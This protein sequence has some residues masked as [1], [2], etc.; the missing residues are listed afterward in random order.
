MS[1]AITPITPA[2]DAI[3]SQHRV[4]IDEAQKRDV[5]ARLSSDDQDKRVQD[6]TAALAIRL[7]RLRSQDQAL[8]NIKDALNVSAAA[9]AAIGDSAAILSRLKELAL[10]STSEALSVSE[11]A[12]VQIEF[13][14]L[15][16]ELD[17]LAT[18][19][20]SGRASTEEATAVE[21][22][23]ASTAIATASAASTNLVAA[24]TAADGT[25][26]AAEMS[27][28]SHDLIVERT[29]VSVHAQAN[30]DSEEALKLLDES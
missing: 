6:D 13:D 2:P 15:K 7:A 25:D 20:E 5:L 19:A 28:V 10:R 3:D 14:S 9:K 18:V 1:N 8:S 27:R 26:A 11:R 21:A 23:R 12:T 29:D 17:R 4:L 24:S 22:N 30:Q 16:A